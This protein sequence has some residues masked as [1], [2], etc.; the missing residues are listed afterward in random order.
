MFT[1]GLDLSS[2][3]SIL[4]STDDETKLGSLY[5]HIKELQKDFQA[6]EECTKP[7]IALIHGKC[8]GGGIDMTLACDIRMVSNDVEFSYDNIEA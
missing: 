8:I 3:A 2:A 7:T 1:A 5:Q 6:I 4:N